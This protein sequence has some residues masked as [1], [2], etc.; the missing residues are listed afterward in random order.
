MTDMT[1]YHIQEGAFTL[2]PQAQDRSVNMLVLNHGPGGLTLVVTR[3]VVQEGEALD[4]MLRRQLRTLGTQVKQLKQQE[5]VALQVGPAALPAFQV[6]LSFK[7][8]NAS[9]Y[10]VQ[11]VVALDGNAVLAF[12]ITCAAPLTSDQAAYAQE[13]LDSFTPVPRD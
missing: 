4:A 7:Q 5:P 1:T 9:V 10:Q 2:P 13:M 3:D 12:T 8:N 11:T 6:A